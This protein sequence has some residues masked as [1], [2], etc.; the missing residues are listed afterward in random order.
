MAVAAARYG[1]NS[2][3]ITAVGDDGFRE[4]VRVALVAFG[5]D[6]RYLR[7]DTTDRT[8]TERAP[9]AGPPPAR[10]G[11]RRTARRQ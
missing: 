1:H 9:S 11:A 5:V 6:A 7:T 2:A 4:Y 10:G 8:P 3:V